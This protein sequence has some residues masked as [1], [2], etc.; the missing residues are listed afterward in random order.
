MFQERFAAKVESGEKQQTVRPTPKR[1][2]KAGDKLSLRQWTG[3][4]YRSKQRLLRE[5][6]CTDVSPIRFDGKVIKLG[7]TS[8]GLSPEESERFA[9]ADGFENLEAM[10]AWFQSTHSLPFSGVVITWARQ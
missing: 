4:A 5:A 10:A 6:I 1:P 7:D 3:K 8:P 9:R 2:V